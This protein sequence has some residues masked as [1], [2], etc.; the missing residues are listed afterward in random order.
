MKLKGFAELDEFLDRLA[1]NISLAKKTNKITD[2]HL[3][4]TRY[5]RGKVA[6]KTI[7]DIISSTGAE[8]N[9]DRDENKGF[10][11]K[12][13]G[14][15]LP[16]VLLW[17]GEDLRFLIE[18]ESTNSSDSRVIDTDLQHYINSM[19]IDLGQTFPEYWLLIYTLPDSVV[20]DWPTW[21]YG[22]KDMMYTSMTGNP[23]RFYK[24]AFKNPKYFGDP[25]RSK[26]D[27]H[28]T[29]YPGVSEY[30]ESTNWKSRKLFFINLTI[31]GLEIDFPERFSGKYYFK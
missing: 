18:Y 28:I 9:Y 8:L 17:K 1:D 15:F 2:E 5:N 16:D 6:H 20:V 7:C 23:H 30:T 10:Y 29:E 14:Y 11:F 22:K 26:S 4:T 3:R 27:R 24:E 21:D 13:G 12:E 25:K 31:S 19:T